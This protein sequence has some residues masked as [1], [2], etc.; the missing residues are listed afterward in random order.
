MLRSS[1]EPLSGNWRNWTP[2]DKIQFL[3]RLKTKTEYNAEYI[4]WQKEYWDKP[5]GFVEDCIRFNRDE[6]MTSYQAET[7]N[8]LAEGQRVCVRSLHTAGKTALA[9]W[10]ILWFSLTRDGRDWKIP[11]T[12]SAWRQLTHFLWPEVRKWAR[13]IRWD[14]VKRQPLQEKKELLHLSLKLRTGTA[15]ALASSDPDAIEGAHATHLL[16]VFDEAK[17]IP[18]GIW[19]SAEGAFATSEKGEALGLAISTPGDTGGRF[20]AIQTRQAGYE[21][22]TVYHWTLDA[23]MASGRVTQEW[24]GQREKQ[25]LRSSAVFQNRVLGEFAVE[26]ERGVIPLSWVEAAIERGRECQDFG[27][28]TSIGVDVGGGLEGADA[29]TVAVCHSW[30]RISE[31]RSYE[32]A[33][34]PTTATMELVGRVSGL[35]RKVGGAAIVDAIGIGAGV[36]HRLVEMGFKAE[37]F[38]ASKRTDYR[39]QSGELGFA[40]WR[41]AAWWIAREMLDPTSGVDVMLPD[42]NDLIGDL[43]APKMVGITS[44]SKIQ[45]ESK[46]TIRKRLGRSTDKGDAVIQALVGPHLLREMDEGVDVVYRPAR[47]GPEL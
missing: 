30:V 19:D 8:R 6:G 14:V 25:W 5:A 7:L 10:A 2:G 42:D 44:A 12:A 47:I 15:F 18:D 32:A 41:S 39:D 38:V 33:M 16:Y 3:T 27:R 34:D 24:V 40:N 22:W 29:S 20:H 4:A 43:T 21:D 35:Q 23:V 9:A 36:L 1:I 31:V 11:T 45:V 17:A 13:R 26:T 28:V 37:G 46:D